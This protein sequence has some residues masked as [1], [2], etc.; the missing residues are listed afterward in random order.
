MDFAIHH[1]A[2]VSHSPGV[3]E[4]PHAQN[5]ARLLIECLYR[6]GVRHIFGMPGSHST[7]VYDAIRQHG[8]IQTT[9]C[10]NEQSGAF[11][12]DGY[13]RATGRPGV[14]CTTAGPGAT[15]ALTG[16]AEAFSDSVPVLLVA[17]HVNHDRV[18]EPCGRYHEI[19]LEGIFRPSVRF[20]GTVMKPDQIPAMTDEAFEAMG[21]G[22]P[23]PAAILF[24]QDL[25][26]M[27]AQ[28]APS[29]TP[30]ELRRRTPSSDS[31]RQV[32]ERI[33]QSRRPAILAGG[34]ALSS[35]ADD[36]IG[37]LARRL[38]CPVVTTLNGKGIVDERSPFSCGH[39][40]TRRAR[41]VL[42]RADLLIAIGCRFTETFTASGTTP[43]PKSLIQIDIDPRQIGLNYPVELGIVGD[44]RTLLRAIVTA[45]TPAESHG[46]AW[47]HV[48]QR[49][50]NA[51]QLKPEWLIDTLRAEIP[52]DSIVFAD[53]CEMGLRMQTDFISYAPRT[54]FY[55]SNYATLGWGFPAAL[56]GAIGRRDRWTVN[57]SGDG[58]F[59]MTAQELATAVRY[60]LHV[61][62]VVHNDSTYGAIKAIQRNHHEDRSIDVYLNNPDF[63][64]LGESFGM[65]SCRARNAEEFAI[66]VRQALH[67]EGPSLIEVP[68]QWRS[69]RI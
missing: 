69:L 54:F 41:M 11:M 36:E 43:I 32:T 61:I 3:V 17:G 35:G 59:L 51:P 64:K 25:M 58:G 33:A 40:R 9:L 5:G 55:P 42:S 38:G 24:P 57:V 49:G 62:T 66:A 56:G 44:A 46:D 19:D 4:T 45:L 50:R 15:N 28:S 37:E 48:W 10:R 23:G 20:I 53:A 12:A 47:M 21:A 67:R 16:I 13:A 2:G 8:G 1:R 29:A 27:P 22:R 39:G 31:I 68:S 30:A 26:A 34:G 14:I 18:H 60:D 7:Y 63:V 6:H 65:P 52:E